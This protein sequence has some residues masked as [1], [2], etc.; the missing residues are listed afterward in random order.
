MCWGLEKKKAVISEKSIRVTYSRY[1]IRYE[2][3]QFLFTSVA[4]GGRQMRG[5]CFV[6]M[7][8]PVVLPNRTSPY[9]SSEH[10]NQ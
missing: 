2:R 7:Y 10:S 9:Q 6:F 8:F 4:F 1:L 5:S 3:T